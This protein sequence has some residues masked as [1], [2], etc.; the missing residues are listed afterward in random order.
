MKVIALPS[1]KGHFL[2]RIFYQHMVVG[3][4]EGIAIA[5]IDLGL[6]GGGFALAVLHVD[7]GGLQSIA[8][9]AHQ[10]LFLGGLE[11]VV[12][13][14]VG[15]DR[16]RAAV[17]LV[18]QRLKTFAENKKLQLGGD[19][20]HQ[21]HLL[22]SLQLRFQDRA[23]RMRHR[24]MRMVVEGVTQH[25]CRAFQPRQWPQ[26]AQVRFQGVITVT[27]GPTGGGVTVDCQHLH[28]GGQQVVARM[29]FFPGR[30]TKYSAWKRLP[31]S[32]PCMSG[33][34]AITVSITP[35]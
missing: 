30:R 25:Q 18:R 22:Q 12:V 20:R 17:A 11:D 27:G 14:V 10:A 5:D 3:H 13:L 6:S 15:A 16:G 26:R 23:R 34:A 35:S 8:H 21:T 33:I 19:S 28:I 31:I 9:A 7:T 2:D 24:R 29:G 4:R 1:W 32:R